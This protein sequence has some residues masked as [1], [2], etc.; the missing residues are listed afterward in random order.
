MKK[1]IPALIPHPSL[2]A[3]TVYQALAFDDALRE[4]GFGLS[5]TSQSTSVVEWEGTGDV[6][7]MC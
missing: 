6:A 2:L 7:Y 1:T 4:A 5:E 3:H